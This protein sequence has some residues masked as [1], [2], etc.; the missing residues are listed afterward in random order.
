MPGYPASH[1]CLRLL[2]TDA[3]YLY[4]WADQW[5]LKGTD[6][7]QAKGTPVIVFGSYPFGGSKPWFAVAQNAK[8][9]ELSPEQMKELVSPH[10]E[11]I[12]KEQGTQDQVRSNES[13]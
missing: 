8:A 12:L 5:V 9:I 13:K 10:L 11:T 1:S 2:E 6:N 7:I 4:D 3:R